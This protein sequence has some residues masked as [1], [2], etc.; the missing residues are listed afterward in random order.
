MYSYH[1]FTFTTG[2]YMSPMTCTVHATC[3]RGGRHRW[4]EHHVKLLIQ[5]HFRYSRGRIAPPP[6]VLHPP[7]QR[8][9]INAG[10]PPHSV[11]L[12]ENHWWKSHPRR[13]RHTLDRSAPHALRSAHSARY[14]AA[15]ALATSAA[16]GGAARVARARRVAPADA[17]SAVDPRGA[18]FGRHP[19]NVV[20]AIAGRLCGSDA[21]RVIDSAI[22]CGTGDATL[23]QMQLAC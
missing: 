7:R 21:C 23:S 4:S 12:T 6:N 22:Y 19:A 8:G 16:H 1:T 15:L 13:K 10:F 14:A 5:S 11:H 18:V 20:A 3:N 2:R 9:G 17:R